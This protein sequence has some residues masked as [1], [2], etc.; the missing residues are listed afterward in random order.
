MRNINNTIVTAG[1]I[2]TVAVTALTGCKN[3]HPNQPHDER[4]EGRVKDDTTI[5]KRVKES[6]QGEPVYK[7]EA[8]EV[9]TYGGIVQLSGFVNLPA[10]KQRAEEITRRVPGVAQVVNALVLKP[11][12]MLSPTGQS[13]GERLTP[14]ANTNSEAPQPAKSE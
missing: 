4:S 3:L 8:V 5:T 13:T 1:L 14:P 7:F 11:D 2:A 9:N 10:Q 6:L 12:S